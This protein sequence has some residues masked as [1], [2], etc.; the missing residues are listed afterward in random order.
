MWCVKN[1]GQ[2][3]VFLRVRLFFFL[4]NFLNLFQICEQFLI[5]IFEFAKVLNYRIFS[6]F[7][8]IFWKFW[9]FSN[10]WIIFEHVNIFRIREQ[11][12]NLWRV[13]RIREH[14]LNS[15]TFLEF[16]LVL[17]MKTFFEHDNIFGIMKTFFEHDNIFGICE[18]C[19]RIHE[20]F[21][22]PTRTFNN[23]SF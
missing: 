14:F 19:F 1:Y 22:N 20:H 8:N 21:L 4:L 17:N 3:Y 6:K 9:T 18:H 16:I 5:H 11:F 12:W 13:F 15:W 2:R 7:V 23:F 10:G